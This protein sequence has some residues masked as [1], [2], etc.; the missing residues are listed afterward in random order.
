MWNVIKVLPSGT[1]N[2]DPWY[3]RRFVLDWCAPD[4]LLFLMQNDIYNLQ[5]L[6]I[7]STWVKCYLAFVFKEVIINLIVFQSTSDPI[8][9]M[10]FKKNSI[11]WNFF[12]ST[13]LSFFLLLMIFLWLLKGLFL[14]NL[15]FDP[16][17]GEHGL[18]AM[19]HR[20]WYIAY[21]IHHIGQL[22]MGAR[23][24]L[25]INMLSN[26][27]WTMR[28]GQCGGNWDPWLYRENPRTRD[29]VVHGQDS[30]WDIGTR[31]AVNQ[32]CKRW[33]ADR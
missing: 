32:N 10:N 27:Q 4:R 31:W 25:H 11:N 22:H 30:S 3:W 28:T 1:I 5:N 12:R 18:S 29:P 21:T 15:P 9:S 7:V 13:Y 20:I 8:I 2:W 6:I 17:M 14:W 19:H 23:C 24:V 26:V 33:T 16:F